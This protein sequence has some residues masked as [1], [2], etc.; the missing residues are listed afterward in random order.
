MA[1]TGRSPALTE[2]G[3][4]VLCLG[5]LLLILGV[6]YGSVL[7][8]AAGLVALVFL[9]A[10][11]VAFSLRVA[12]LWQRSLELVWWLPR[13]TSA[14]GLIAQRPFE[15]HVT[16][17]NRGPLRLGR[18]TL[19]P[20]AS[21]CIEIVEAPPSVVVTPGTA[22]TSRLFLRSLQAGQWSVHGAALRLGDRGDLFSI[23]AYFPSPLSL[24]ILPRPAG[25]V[26]LPPYRVHGSAGEERIGAHTLR[27]RGP[28][29]ELRE[30]RE[31][32]PGDPFKLIAWKA[33]ARAPFGR[34][35]VRELERESLLVHYLVLD[36]SATM[37]EGPPGQWKLD[38]ALELCQ[39]Y[40]RA[41]LEDGDRIGLITFDGS[42]YRHLKPGEGPPQRLH[43][44]E[45]L[46]E[47]MTVVH[48]EFIAMT[49]GELCAAV[50]R[51]LRYQEG[52]E[53]RVARAPEIE[54][55]RAW[56]QI[57]VAPHGELIN[58]PLLVSAA[59]KLLAQGEA[60]RRGGQRPGPET[61]RAAGSDGAAAAD[62]KPS[63]QIVRR[64]CLERGIELPYAQR[65][66]EGRAQGLGAALEACAQHGGARVVLISDLLGLRSELPVL[67]RA[68]ALCHRRGLR[69]LCLR[70]ETRRY[71]P[72]NLLGHPAAVRAAEIFSW[73][74]TR[75]EAAMQRSL[76]QLGFHVIAVGPEDTWVQILS[77]KSPARAPAKDDPDPKAQT[78]HAP[79]VGDSDAL[80]S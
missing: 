47:V 18:C 76:A 73:E 19:R 9:S 6:G 41:V 66:A 80:R 36:I 46:L 34:P 45:Q 44:T 72:K 59:Q 8:S 22:T 25:R 43:I 32:V 48:P 64:L 40:A 52:I 30:L 21:R 65:S 71:L 14:E 2:R 50:A 17:R 77:Q 62:L 20:I 49:D 35:L 33:S 11:F 60:Q 57:V 13:A 37:R 4:Y 70:P 5:L 53:V 56:S 24:K 74:Q 27:R 79:S 29:G 63:L 23:E 69:L 54:D 16:L 75:Q 68:V 51:Y 31:Y 26:K 38:H 28:G 55:Q 7:L 3:C 12:L 78:P 10:A 15:I 61:T 42:I 67:S 58:L 39:A 1:A